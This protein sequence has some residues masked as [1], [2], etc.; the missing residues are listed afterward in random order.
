M[1][2]TLPQTGIRS[3]AL[4]SLLN[5]FV[6]V[7]KSSKNLEEKILATLAVKTFISD[8]GKFIMTEPLLTQNRFNISNKKYKKRKAFDSKSPYLSGTRS[9]GSTR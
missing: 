1:L 9:A 8:P 7:L 4:N 6:N 5:E 2:S 3:V